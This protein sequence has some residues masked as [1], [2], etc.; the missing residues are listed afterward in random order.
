M[1]FIVEDGTGIVGA[2]SYSSVEVA[3]DYATFWDYTEWLSLDDAEK[4]K[5]LILASSYMDTY[6]DYPS[7]I[8]T[9]TQGLL[10]P[11]EPFLDSDGRK[12]SGLPE[13]ITEACI[14]IAVLL[15]LGLKPNERTKLLKAQSY[16]S[17]SETYL[18]SWSESDN[19]KL[20]L[21]NILTKLSRQGLGGKYAKQVTLIRG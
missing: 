8:L 3:D 7:R 5:F 21:K 14:R 19:N 16:G 10:Y 2:T 15:N 9:N 11:R 17:S 1:Q 18:G 20:E 6:L 13:G 4:E 12:V